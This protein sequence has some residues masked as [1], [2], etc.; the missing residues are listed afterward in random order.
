MTTVGHIL[1]G[2]L[3]AAVTFF[4]L[5]KVEEDDRDRTFEITLWVII[6]IVFLLGIFAIIF[7][8]AHL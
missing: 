5:L 4:L 1:L 7:T 8:V 2:L 6:G 3:A